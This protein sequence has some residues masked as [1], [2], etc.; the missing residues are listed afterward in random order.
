M[1]QL[2][3]EPTMTNEIDAWIADE[4]TAS[5]I[6]NTDLDVIQRRFKHRLTI[7]RMRNGGIAIYP[8]FPGSTCAAFEDFMARHT[9]FQKQRLDKRKI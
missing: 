4:K 1:S 3:N 9:P 8:E 2:T 6:P 5:G 7:T